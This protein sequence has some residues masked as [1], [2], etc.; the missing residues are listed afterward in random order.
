MFRFRTNEEAE[1]WKL[2]YVSAFRRQYP[3]DPCA[4]AIRAVRNLREAHGE[5]PYQ[6]EE[7]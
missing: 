5:D 4:E 2:V 7:S 6:E 1:L 3:C